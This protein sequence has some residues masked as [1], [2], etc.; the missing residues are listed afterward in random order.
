MT[1]RVT[2]YQDT[3]KPLNVRQVAE[4]QPRTMDC[5]DCHNRP[6]HDFQSPDYAIDLAL[7][8]GRIS[9][10]LPEI[11]KTSVEAMIKEY[12]SE[13]E[14]LR[15]IAGAIT[16]FYRL[17]YP[18]VALRNEKEI[19]E[20][21]LNVQAAYQRN[22]FPVMKASWRDYPDDIGH[23]IFP[24]CMRCHDGKHT[25]S[26]GTIIM[27]NC[28]TCHIIIA[29]GP[30]MSGEVITAE[31]GLDFNHPVDIGDAWKQGR[32]YDCHTGVQP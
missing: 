10:E 8:T 15:G 2:I 4:A 30:R 13:Q 31:T 3:A 20:A 12:P 16:D 23:F 14:A 11:K 27:N 32:C 19:K 26:S 6:S 1:G 24:G 9:P 21:I 22:I 18:K 29:Q 28:R 7:A 17:N 5:M 25:S